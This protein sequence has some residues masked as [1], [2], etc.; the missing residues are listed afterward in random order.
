MKK[1]GLSKMIL[2]LMK[3]DDEAY[4]W[5]DKSDPI[6]LERDEKSEVVDQSEK[7]TQ[8]KDGTKFEEVKVAQRTKFEE[9]SLMAQSEQPKVDSL[10]SD[11]DKPPNYV[12]LPEDVREKVCLAECLE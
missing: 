5:S 6:E 9:V 12:P 8:S 11:S 7:L 10:S 2:G 4:D 1:T 3:K